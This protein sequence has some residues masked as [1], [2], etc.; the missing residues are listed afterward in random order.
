[1]L[2]PVESTTR[3][4]QSLDGIWTI[5]FDPEHRGMDL[6]YPGAP[7]AGGH[8]IAVP[9][10]INE[11][12]MDRELYHNMDWVWYFR[13]FS[14]SPAW[15]GR[16]L[17]LR[18]GAVNYRAEVFLNQRRLGSHEG[19]YTPFEFEV[20]DQV[21]FDKPN[22]LVV[23]VDNLLDATTIPQGRLDPAVGGVANWRRDNYPD[24]HYDF[25]PFTGIHRPVVLYATG[26]ARIE[27]LKLTSSVQGSAASIQLAAHYT[28]RADRL[29]VSCAELGRHASFAL[30]ASPEVAEGTF[31]VDGAVTWSP[32]H[33]KLYEFCFELFRD[34]VR[35]DHYVLPY[36]V[37]TMEVR[38][39]QLLLNGAPLFLRGF[40]RHE[41]TPVAG[42]G[43]NLPFLVKD[44][45]LMRWIGANSFR[46]SH[47]PYSEEDMQMADRLGFMVIDETPANTLSMKAVIDPVLRQRLAE[48]HRQQVQELFERDH[49][50]PS[51]IMWSLGN[52][53]ETHEPE[54]R[55]YFREI[56]AYARTLDTSRPIAF[57]LNS[58]PDSEQEA[59]VFDVICLNKYPSWYVKCGRLEQIDELL[60]EVVGFWKK[61]KKPI[62]MSEF[63]ADALP[64]LHN[65]H[66]LMWSEEF[67]VEM[68]RR[69]IEFCERHPYVC[70]THVWNL[71]DFKVGQHVGRVV[72]NWKGVFTRDRHPKMAAHMLRELWRKP[73]ANRDFT[74]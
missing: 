37:R 19:G 9:G 41:D 6:N 3:W 56:V 60:G 58:G 49:N 31:H 61:Y 16:R 27:K 14:V 7:P 34:G 36:G 57:V 48:R 45:N 10:S 70:G 62:L 52:E 66:T 18:F 30:T 33:P 63:G 17:F 50:H 13:T 28:G 26:D 73:P 40:G 71:A 15:S 24:V 11:Q 46:T 72:N 39:G 5:H 22:V 35:I 32:E 25:F 29:D 69:V 12:L 65:E 21:H 47:Y 23:R 68:L 1:M 42:K 55:G 2:Y 38:G 8:E 51:V 54:T 67:Q 74:P 53:C 64:G 4:N 44:Y 20:T 43:L 59:D